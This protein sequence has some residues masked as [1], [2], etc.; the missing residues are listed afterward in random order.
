MRLARFIFVIATTALAAA[1]QPQLLRT[2][3]LPAAPAGGYQVPVVLPDLGHGLIQAVYPDR[4]VTIS[5]QDGTT[6]RTTALPLS[7]ASYATD[8]GGY[9]IA[10]CL[11]GDGRVGIISVDTSVGITSDVIKTDIQVVD[12]TTQTVATLVMPYMTIG[13]G[14]CLFSSDNS[15]LYVGGT[16]PLSVPRQFGPG[17]FAVDTASMQL[18]WVRSTGYDQGIGNMIMTKRGIVTY[19]QSATLQ[20]TNT[21]NC[22]TSVGT[23]SSDGTWTA[24][25]QGLLPRI[26]KPMAVSPAG[27]AYLSSR[28]IDSSGQLTKLLGSPLFWAWPSSDPWYAYGAG[29]SSLRGLELYNNGFGITGNGID[30]NPNNP[31]YNYYGFAARRQSDG[32]DFVVAARTDSTGAAYLDFFQ[33]TPPP[34]VHYIANAASFAPGSVAPGA[35]VTLMG[36]GL[37]AATDEYDVAGLQVALT[38]GKTQ[39]LFDGKPVRLD[40]AQY[41]QVNARIPSGAA[42]GQ[43]QIRVVVNGN[44]VA[45]T[46][47][48]VVAQAEAIFLWHPDPNHWDITQPIL[49]DGNVNLIGDPAISPAYQQVRP[50]DVFIAWGTGGGVT[51]PPMDDTVVSP[52]GLH[53]LVNQL[54]VLVDGNPAQ[55]AYAGRA[56]GYGSLDQLNVVVPGGLTPGAH[57]VTVVSQGGYAITYPG[58]LWVK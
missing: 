44:T 22:Q 48:T 28:V 5:A 19:T 34:L 40:F 47:V 15:T 32:T 55:I 31:S 46:Q 42:L 36:Q 9:W 41:G 24:L 50:G 52:G 58:A 43:H 45:T 23:V 35:H 13:E 1:A 21:G 7:A 49:T 56:P 26:T 38:L 4:V 29:G 37:T 30:L 11:A 54:Q 27:Y 17:F 18:M 53:Y 2:V 57:D 25:Y 6:T 51:S 33:V 10:S 20:C 16:V 12:T 8:G 3:P 39:V 14:G